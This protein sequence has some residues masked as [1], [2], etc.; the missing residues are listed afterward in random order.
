MS[1]TASLVSLSS[2][3]NPGSPG[4]SGRQNPS[5]LTPL[6]PVSDGAKVSKLLDGP[7][8]FS[9]TYEDKD[10]DWMLVGDVSRTN[11]FGNS[12]ET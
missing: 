6:L 8:E 3:T 7:S 2:G 4:L 5:P 9:L 1:P 12:E 10:G 11:G